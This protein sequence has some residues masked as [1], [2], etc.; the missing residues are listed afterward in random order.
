[1]NFFKKRII[2]FLSFFRELFVYHHES[3][4]FRAKVLSVVILGD[5][6]DS[7]CNDVILKNLCSNIYSNDE[8]RASILLKT[9][10]EY[11]LKNKNRGLVGIEDLIKNIDK[12]V[13]NR[14]KLISKIDI[15]LLKEFLECG[16][17]EQDIDL[18][19]KIIDF[20]EDTKKYGQ[21]HTKI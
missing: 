14:K 6:E 8:V 18:Q 10:H 12:S 1:M 15:D 21:K 19:I 11:V 3:L 4:E 20:L 9:V 13:K 5:H 17:K 7:E 2:L 16:T